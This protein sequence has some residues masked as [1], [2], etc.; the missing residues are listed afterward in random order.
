[1]LLTEN[2]ETQGTQVTHFTQEEHRDVRIITGGE[3]AITR[4]RVK[5]AAYCRVSTDEEVQEASLE[6]QQS[7]YLEYIQEHDD[8]ELVGIYAEDG[9]SATSA[10]TR[11]VLMQLM[12]DCRDGRV[13]MILAK[14]VSRFS[15]NTVDCLNLVR[16]LKALHVSVVFEKEQIDTGSMDNELF[17][18][19]LSSFAT[20]ESRSISLNVKLGIR[21][22]FQAGAYHY[23][24]PPYGYDV[25]D[26]GLVPNRREKPIVEEIFSRALRGDDPGDIARELEERRIPTKYAA[27]WTKNTITAILTNMTY[28]GDLLLQ[29]TWCD[30]N[31]K[32]HVNRG[33]KD[34]YFAPD[35]HEAIV[36]REEFICVN[37]VLGYTDP[38]KNVLSVSEDALKPLP[39]EESGD[40]VKRPRVTVIK[41]ED[42][43]RGPDAPEKLK[44]A[45]YCRV[46]TDSEEQES[47]YEVQCS[48]Y[49]DLICRNPD[50]TMVEIY[51]D[52]GITGTSMRKRDS[53]NRMIEDAMAGKINLILTKSISRFARNTLDCLTVVRKLKSVGVGVSFEKEGIDTL[54]G[55]GELILTILASIA[56]QE[57]ESISQNVKLGIRYRFQQGIPMINC[58]RFLG[59]DKKNGKLVINSAEATVV[60]RIF[61]DFLD[62]YS[63]KMIATNLRREGVLSGSKATSWFV[64]SI[65]YI[66]RNEKYAGDLLLQ[67]TFIEDVLT[68]KQVVNKGRVPRYYVED[69]HP[70]IIPHSIFQRAA[71]ELWLRGEVYENH[72][73]AFGSRYL[74]RGRT[75]CKCGTLMRGVGQRKTSWA[76]DVCGVLWTEK[77]VKRQVGSAVERLPEREDEIRSRIAELELNGADQMKRSTAQREEWT[78]RNLLVEEKDRIIHMGDPDDACISEEDF[79]KRTREKDSAFWLRI[80]EKVVP[81]EKVCFRGGIEIQVTGKPQPLCQPAEEETVSGKGGE[82]QVIACETNAVKPEEHAGPA[83]PA[84][85]NV[86]AEESEFVIREAEVLLGMAEDT[87]EEEDA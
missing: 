63:P 58:S 8:W 86:P 81:G 18:S 84:K 27:T 70:P 78:L 25:R 49:H 79:R 50:W 1:M 60:R 21:H 66:L 83:E 26:G 22:R 77:E 35:I 74:L 75:Y 17:L 68:H 64:S 5:V 54:E 7:H 4:R 57:G 61:R 45:A 39:E 3:Q 53:F 36:T 42:L 15:R 51:A 52:E 14:S 28:T 72:G 55:T 30:E 47:S 33:E 80:V 40:G 85:V 24:R 65:Y 48:H 19:I 16:A 69:A 12:A 10:S 82:V 44:V 73:N 9:L 31:F 37:R 87:D 23:S 41:A 29:K 38:Y 76:C 71:D 67:K 20:E 6:T 56:Q 11:P 13:Q 46:S 62:G 2:R 32:R 43:R 59:Y 34:Q